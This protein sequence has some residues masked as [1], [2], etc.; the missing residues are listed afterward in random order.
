MSPAH[1]FPPGPGEA[2]GSAVGEGEPRG[3]R[4]GHA[5]STGRRPGSARVMDGARCRALL[6]HSHRGPAGALLSPSAVLA[7]VC[8]DPGKPVLAGSRRF[9]RRDAGVDEKQ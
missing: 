5:C 7:D 4:A 1:P 3:G 8:T 9:F 6:T 2:R